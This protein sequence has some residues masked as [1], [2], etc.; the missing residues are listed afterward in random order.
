MADFILAC[1]R[2][3]R[4]GRLPT[5]EQLEQVASLLAPGNISPR[6]TRLIKTHGL[7]AAIVNPTNN[8][9][10][11]AEGGLLLGGVIGQA[12]RWWDVASEPPDGTYALARYSGAT[13]ELLSDITAS[14]TIWYACDEER[15]VVSTSQR[16]VVA[17]L[18][19]FDLDP[20]AVSWLLS[21]GSL[22]P[23]CSWDSRLRRLPGDARLVLDRQAWR[24]TLEQRPAMFEPVARS[25]QQ[26]LELLRDAIAWSCEALDVDTERWLLP[27]SGG[28]DSR[29]ILAFMAR[30]GRR[31]RC[32]TWTMR[33]SLKNPLSDACVARLL[34]RRFG[35][36]HTY[37]FL[38][39]AH[40]VDEAAL[41]RFVEA[42]EGGT[43]DFAAYVDGCAMWSG[44]FAA[45]V[46]GVIRGDEPLGA[47]RRAASLDGARRAGAGTMVADYPQGHL[48]RR[49]GLVDQ[50][51]PARLRPRADEGFE[52]YRDRMSHEGMIPKALAPL[53][54]LKCRY[55]E[56]VNPLLSR[57]ILA[58]VR[59][60]PDELRRYGSAFSA[61][62]DRESRPIPLARFASIP[63]RSWYL[64][65][66]GIV[67]AMV[68]ELTSD[69]VHR[70]LSEEA[71]LTLLAAMASP[72]HSHATVRSRVID[73]MKAAR[74]AL[75]SGL[76]YRLTPPYRGPEPLTAMQLA[77]RATI[78]SKTVAL[79]GRDA[80]ALDRDRLKRPAGQ[81]ARSDAQVS[82]TWRASA[83]SRQ[84]AD[85][86]SDSDMRGGT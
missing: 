46:S 44:F 59:T 58:V 85:S 53:T 24:T 34:A 43:E 19:D 55:L 45:G 76:A 40:K 70:V 54:G 14:R 61:I 64:T 49:L 65:D 22:G 35:A 60:F 77:F 84:E 71:A 38:D 67:R 32:V 39:D 23:E 25:R 18:G 20:A 29:L 69:A 8:G 36:E 63:A 3:D 21:S 79:L 83:A 15:L 72:A 2:E 42:G 48:M 37:A 50:D 66:E 5:L 41:E 56:V 31:P 27:L 26:H 9:V 1:V 68:A 82:R 10:R 17:L 52:A 6:P 78:A 86:L 12:G 80:G 30:S 7:R 13:V 81:S 28:L 11:V 4:T 16:A 73:A 51:W 47:R 57:R 62:A 74:V 33:R 75:P